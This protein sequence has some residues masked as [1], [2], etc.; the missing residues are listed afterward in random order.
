[1]LIQKT[2]PSKFGEIADI[3]ETSTSRIYV[4]NR[5]KKVDYLGYEFKRLNKIISHVLKVN[6]KNKIL[7]KFE[8]K[9]LKY[10]QKLFNKEIPTITINQFI[11]V[12]DFSF[13]AI[14]ERFIDIEKKIIHQLQSN[15]LEAEKNDDEY[16]FVIQNIRLQIN[17]LNKEFSDEKLNQNKT[18]LRIFIKKLQ[19]L[20][21]NLNEVVISIIREEYEEI[22]SL[23]NTILRTEK[24]E[25][26]IS[27]KIFA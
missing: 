10:L 13:Q 20:Y 26:K 6:E 11:K 15:N 17:S 12:I 22:E 8:K 19:I 23:S 16:L 14:N 4:N 18:R 21:R 24:I 1:M 7:L 2:I 25:F 27:N 5:T 9:Y 3:F